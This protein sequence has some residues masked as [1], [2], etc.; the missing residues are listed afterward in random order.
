MAS[1]PA[2]SNTDRWMYTVDFGWI[3]IRSPAGSDVV[4]V[5]RCHDW[6]E[7][8]IPAFQLRSRANLEADS[9][10]RLKP[11]YINLVQDLKHRYAQWLKRRDEHAQSLFV[12]RAGSQR[13]ERT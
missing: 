13:E 1:M 11:E 9:A 7:M 6:A 2:D 3:M 12:R 4:Q 5:V 10:E 8:T